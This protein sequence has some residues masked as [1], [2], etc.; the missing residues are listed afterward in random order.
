M[1]D[2]RLTSLGSLLTGRWSHRSLRIQYCLP[3]CILQYQVQA[4]HLLLEKA[5]HS[6]SVAHDAAVYIMALTPVTL[7]Y[8]YVSYLVL[9]YTRIRSLT[10][11]AG[12][13]SGHCI[14]A[15][16]IFVS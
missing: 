4:L 13:I 12:I 10:V 5:L 1:H 11:I 6:Y 7:C 15:R 3:R 16:S 8:Y 2:Q 14:I 9:N